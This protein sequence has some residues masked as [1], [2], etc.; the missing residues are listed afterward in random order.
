M[1]NLDLQKGK[2]LVLVAHPDDE[3]IWIGGTILVNPEIKWIIF[4]LT[5]SCDH[6]RAP[7][8]RRAVRILGARGIIANADD[9][10]RLA[11]R[12]SVKEMKHILAKK[13]SRKHFDYIFT[14]AAS[15]EYGHAKHRAAH[16]AVKSLLAR[17]VLSA[18]RVICFAYKMQKNSKYAVPH[19]ESD[20]SL[21]L[22]VEIYQKKLNIIKNIYGFS[23]DSFEYK[24][25]SKIER[26]NVAM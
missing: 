6:D 15:G 18:K 3:T 9:E 7:R 19:K 20:F 11:F 21:K 4:S 23:P 12:A 2:A 8:F 10:E 22:P 24:S 26:F 25:C 1:S 5:R 17:K 14:H 16:R 13:L